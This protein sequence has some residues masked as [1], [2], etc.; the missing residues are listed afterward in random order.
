V[1]DIG[2]KANRLAAAT[3]MATLVVLL[4]LILVPPVME[5]L[6]S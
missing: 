4:A 5:L 1:T 2:A 3:A 6:V